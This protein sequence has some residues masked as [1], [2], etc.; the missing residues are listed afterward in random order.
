[1]ARDSE[2]VATVE[3]PRVEEAAVRGVPARTT[4]IPTATDIVRPE[5]AARQ[6]GVADRGELGAR[7]LQ[8]RAKRP[9]NILLVT[10]QQKLN[11]ESRK[12]R[13]APGASNR[14]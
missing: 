13:Q 3:H 8:T 7:A 2:V 1:M 11:K 10:E 9:K 12:T 6:G 5:E 4:Q 14:F